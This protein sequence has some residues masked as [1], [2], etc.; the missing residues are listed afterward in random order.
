MR[1]SL[2]EAGGYS[3]LTHQPSRAAQA[4]Q[5]AAL[6][7][8]FDVVNDGSN[9]DVLQRQ[10]VAR[11]DVRLRARFNHV[12]NAKAHR[13]ECSAFPHP[14]SAEGNAGSAVGIVSNSCNLAERH[15]EREVDDTVLR[16]GRRPG[17]EIRSALRPPLLVRLQPTL[18][19]LGN[20]LL[21]QSCCAGLEGCFTLNAC[22]KPPIV[23]K[24]LNGGRAQG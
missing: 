11:L 12:S 13:S 21:T 18:L 24:D 20:L 23:F 10:S 5:L 3:A 8:W 16:Y 6:P 4:N 7:G 2:K 22:F 1:N 17:G 19:A 15:F 9:R 14:D